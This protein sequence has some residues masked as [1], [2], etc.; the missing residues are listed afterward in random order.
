M[1]T[2]SILAQDAGILA[3]LADTSRA[4]YSGYGGGYGGHFGGFSSNAVRTDAVGAQ[5]ERNGEDAHFFALS[6]QERSH[7][8]ILNHQGQATQLADQAQI[9][10]LALQLCQCCNDQKASIGM[11]EGKLECLGKETALEVLIANTNQDCQ[12]LLGHIA[13]QQNSMNIAQANDQHA[14]MLGILGQITGALSGADG[15]GDGKCKRKRCHKCRCRECECGVTVNVRSVHG[16]N[17]FSDRG[18]GD[19]DIEDVNADDNDSVNAGN[20]SAE[21]GGNGDAMKTVNG[22]SAPSVPAISSAKP[23]PKPKVK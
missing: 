21:N 22:R 16:N 3:L 8:N 17:N 2:E 18:G 10:Q 13:A 11:I 6:G 9:S 14:Q 5:V 1:K 20:E 23:K 4:G 19:G 15:D 12:D 7:F